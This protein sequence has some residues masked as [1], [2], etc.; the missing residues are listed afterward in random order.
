MRLAPEQAGLEPEP[1]ARHGRVR[2]ARR[3]RR[4]EQ[5]V[6]GPVVVARDHVPAGPNSSLTLAKWEASAACN[7]TPASVSVWRVNRCYSGERDGRATMVTLGWAWGNRCADG[8]ALCASGG[9][10]ITCADGHEWFGWNGGACARN[11][12]FN[13]GNGRFFDGATCSACPPRCISCNSTAVCTACWPPHEFWSNGSCGLCGD[14]CSRCNGEAPNYCID[15]SREHNV[16]GVCARL[17]LMKDTEFSFGSVMVASLIVFLVSLTG[18]F[19]IPLLLSALMSRSYR[20]AE[21]PQKIDDGNCFVALALI[22]GAPILEPSLAMFSSLV[23]WLGFVFSVACALLPSV[24]LNP[25]GLNDFGNAWGLHGSDIPELLER[26]AQ[27]SPGQQAA[28]VDPY[29]LSGGARDAL[30][31]LHAAWNL[32]AACAVLSGLSRLAIYR[33]FFVLSGEKRRAAA[34]TRRAAAAAD[35][36]AHPSPASPPPCQHSDLP[37][38]YSADASIQQAHAA[39]AA[40]AISGALCGLVS[41]LLSHTASQRLIAETSPALA[42]PSAFAPVMAVASA[43]LALGAASSWRLFCTWSL[44]TVGAA[45]ALPFVPQVAP[46][47]S[48]AAAAAT[49]EAEMGALAASVVSGATVATSASGVDEASSST[50]L[51]EPPP[52]APAAAKGEVVWYTSSSLDA[53]EESESIRTAT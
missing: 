37:A 25:Q 8:C 28:G 36:V 2:G 27:A 4:R 45:A 43:L 18:G 19:S 9:R 20:Q 1:D 47:P 46:P 3:A 12:K 29:Q 16:L 24:L 7:G 15:C 22:I 30:G 5:R 31:A 13:C 33:L 39:F 10:C 17:S 34:I 32:S 11:G 53:A 23:G 42:A 44:V 49:R 40:L 38:L 21:A 14:G 48:A 41:S 50:A 52:G 35:A 51:I 6:R 26:S